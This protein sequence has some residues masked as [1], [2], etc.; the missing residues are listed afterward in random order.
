[1]L[2]ILSLCLSACLSVCLLVAAPE[3]V[4]FGLMHHFAYRIHDPS[5]QDPDGEEI[6]VGTTRLETLLGDVAVC[7]HPKDPRYAH[8][9]GRQLE[10]P[11]H[12]GLRTTLFCR[13]LHPSRPDSVKR[14]CLWL[15]TYSTICH[16]HTGIHQ[17]PIQ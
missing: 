4:E 15:T 14:W 11:I 17:V 1:M 2:S 7:V 6:V 10:H 5:G 3:Q 13:C 12:S 8:L 16:M 9:V